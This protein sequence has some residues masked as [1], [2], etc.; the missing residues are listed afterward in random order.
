M[1]RY[2]I[3]G[4]GVD[5]DYGYSYERCNDGHWVFFNDIV[6]TK[7]KAV[8]RMNNDVLDIIGYCYGNLEQA[9]KYFG[10]NIKLKEIDVVDL[11]TIQYDELIAKRRELELEL[12]TINQKI[13]KL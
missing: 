1:Q 13:K 4:S 10:P 8:L 9:E 7:I 12:A 2:N 5:G 11:D 6:S 3:K